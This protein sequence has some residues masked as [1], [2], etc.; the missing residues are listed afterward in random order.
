MQGGK[1]T[2]S[3][4]I[5]IDL[6]TYSMTVKVRLRMLATKLAASIVIQFSLIVCEGNII[7]CTYF[8]IDMRRKFSQLYSTLR[9][10]FVT[11]EYAFPPLIYYSRSLSIYR[12]FHFVFLLPSTNRLA[13]KNERTTCPQKLWKLNRLFIVNEK[14]FGRETTRKGS[15]FFFYFG[16]KIIHRC[17]YFPFEFFIRFSRWVC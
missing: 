8:R 6:I 2:R 7:E 17:L 15:L 3:R 13:N 14:T 1:K 5:V 11:H 9:T 12:R 4:H 10:C 16:L